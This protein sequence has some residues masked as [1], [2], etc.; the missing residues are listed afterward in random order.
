MHRQFLVHIGSSFMEYPTSNQKYLR[1]K[2]PA[3]LLNMYGYFLFPLFPKY[4]HLTKE[5]ISTMHSL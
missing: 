3:S 2:I 5:H 1:K 4:C